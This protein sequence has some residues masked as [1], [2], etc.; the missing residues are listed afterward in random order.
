MSFLNHSPCLFFEAGSLMGPEAHRFSY[1]G[2][3]ISFMDLLVF[4]VPEV[5]ITEVTACIARPNFLHGF[6]VS[7]TRVCLNACG[8]LS[9]QSSPSLNNNYVIATVTK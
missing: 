7:E 6:W 9:T 1:A 5:C 8:T 2:W 4:N 3:L